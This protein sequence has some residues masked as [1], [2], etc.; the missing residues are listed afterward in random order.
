MTTISEFKLAAAK[1]L[2]ERCYSGGTL[3]CDEVSSIIGAQRTALAY[4]VVGVV[5]F[6]VRGTTDALSAWTFLK[7]PRNV[8]HWAGRMASD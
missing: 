5:E 8:A 1:V 3:I 2:R 4:E 6:Y 7:A